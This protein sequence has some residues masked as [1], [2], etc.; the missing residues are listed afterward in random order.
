MDG[1]SL[2]ESLPQYEGQRS[3]ATQAVQGDPLEVAV[4]Q[5]GGQPPSPPPGSYGR[6]GDGGVPEAADI[7]GD[8]AH[9]PAARQGDERSRRPAQGDERPPRSDRQRGRPVP[10]DEDGP[11][12][13]A[14]VAAPPPQQ[15][16][17]RSPRVAAE[18]P[19]APPETPVGI[20]SPQGNSGHRK[21]TLP[22]NVDDSDAPPMTPP[23]AG[24]S[25]P[26]DGLERLLNG[27]LSPGSPSAPD[28]GIFDD[29]DEGFDD[30]AIFQPLMSKQ[31]KPGGDGAEPPEEGS[32]PQPPPGPPP[33]VRRPE[34]PG[35]QWENNTLDHLN[36]AKALIRHAHHHQL[37]S[38]RHIQKSHKRQGTHKDTV[39][40]VIKKKISMTGDL[41]KALEDR[42]A[43]VEDTI[44]Q[45]GECL[46]QLQRAHRSKW[47]PLTVCDR[48]LELREA[49]PPQGNA[50]DLTQEALEHERQALSESRQELGDQVQSSKEMLLALDKLKAEIIEDLSHKRHGLRI[51]RSC[52]SPTMKPVFHH[53]EEQRTVLPRLHEVG[54][55]SGP[56]SP[57]DTLSGSGAQH[58]TMRQGDT[59]ALIARAVKME[60]DALRLC[61]ESDVIMLQTHRECTRAANQVQNSLLRRT[62]ETEELKRQLEAHLRELDEAIGQMDLSLSKTKKKLDAHDAPL[63]ALDKQFNLRG[64]RTSREGIRDHVHDELESHLGGVQKNVKTLQAK[65][66]ETETLLA[67]LRASR[68]QLSE[69]YRSKLQSLAIDDK[70]LKITPRKAI[71]LNR[72]DPRS[73]RCKAPPAKKTPSSYAPSSA[74]TPEGF[75]G[76]LP[77]A[78]P[79]LEG[80]ARG[81]RLHDTSPP[82]PRPH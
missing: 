63:R 60:E 2:S 17:N 65:Y 28:A 21:P 44:R 4:L 68:Q 52:L 20:A 77:S 7:Q 35:D 76:Y 55:F 11:P 3:P 24:A 64:Q 70:C 71:E 58:E 46:F 79:E 73:G 42:H 54:S 33:A 18:P 10:S 67:Q 78:S 29:D 31:A 37:D 15:G 14:V 48:R 80:E 5:P 81:L 16:D 50:R 13:G 53:R 36:N 41:I 8:Q 6:Q 82:A 40:N 66:Q 12:N 75:S 61:N 27:S 45:V 9:E 38:E 57:Q 59:K 32:W 56:P 49:R 39:F 25:Q 74:R 69:D 26:D 19:V 47:A 51:D 22:G 23:G 30:D 34:R 43:S 1:S 72:M 62:A